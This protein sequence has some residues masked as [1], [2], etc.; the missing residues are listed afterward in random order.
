MARF[1]VGDDRSQCT[2][3]RHRLSAAADH[4]RHQRERSLRQAGLRLCRRGRH[5]K[6]N[7]AAWLRRVARRKAA[8]KNPTQYYRSAQYIC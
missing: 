2:S 7:A 6:V 1:V 4:I 8:R 3:R 5:L